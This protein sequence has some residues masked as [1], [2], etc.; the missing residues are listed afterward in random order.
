MFVFNAKNCIF[1]LYI[2]QKV[3]V[4]NSCDLCQILENRL[5]LLFFN[6]IAATCNG[7]WDITGLLT[8]IFWFWML[9]NGIFALNR[10]QKVE[11]V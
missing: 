10:T 2:T 3:E 4:V 8:E 7:L 9:K 1:A 5:K 11:V 6:K